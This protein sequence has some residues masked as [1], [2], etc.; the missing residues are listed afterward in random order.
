MAKVTAVLIQTVRI[1]GWLQVPLL[2]LYIVSGYVWASTGDPPSWMSIER[3]EAIHRNMDVPLFVLLGGH[4]V[5]S[6]YLALGRL[7][8]RRPRKRKGRPRLPHKTR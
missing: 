5:P 4:V 8:R 7:S 1:T 3:A 6:V 2:A